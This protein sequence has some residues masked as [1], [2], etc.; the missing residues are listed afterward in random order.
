MYCG[1]P[2]D[3]KCCRKC[4]SNIHHAILIWNCNSF[5]V[6]EAKFSF[7]HYTLFLY[8]IK[9]SITNSVIISRD[10]QHTEQFSCVCF[11][12]RH[13]YKFVPSIIDKLS[14]R[15]FSVSSFLVP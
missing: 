13:A 7:I 3:D 12:E 8:F 5:V 10:G 14:V 9:F 2:D 11:S 6:I 4:E 1:F 15:I